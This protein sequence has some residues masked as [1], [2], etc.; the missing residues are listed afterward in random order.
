MSLTSSA[1]VTGVSIHAPARGATIHI[2]FNCISAYYNTFS[3]N[4]HFL[5]LIFSDFLHLFI[6]IIPL[7]QR[8]R[9]PGAFYDNL[10]FADS[11]YQRV[12]LRI[13]RV[14]CSDMLHFIFPIT[15]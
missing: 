6:F 1:L 12:I 3:A 4:V 10:I 11:Y 5:G 7:R 14:L 9:L 15:A 8:T 13:E 2:V